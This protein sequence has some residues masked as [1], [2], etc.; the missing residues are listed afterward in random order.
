[1]YFEVKV[2]NICCKSPRTI[3]ISLNMANRELLPEKGPFWPFFDPF[4]N[5]ESIFHRS[6][7]SLALYVI[8]SQNYIIIGFIWQVIWSIF[9]QVMDF[10]DM[11]SVKTNHYF[12]PCLMRIL[13]YCVTDGRGGRK[14]DWT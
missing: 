7:I 9:C 12:E 1:M 5:F 8:I 2:I 10:C 14:N 13:R 11:M 4:S 6:K 3:K